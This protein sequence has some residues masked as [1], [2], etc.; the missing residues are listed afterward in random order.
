MRGELSKRRA[1]R[2]VRGSTALVIAVGLALLT[3]PAAVSA[4]D[5][6]GRTP[7]VLFPAFH[8]TKLQVTVKN[9]TV[10]PDCP[11]SGSFED[12]FLN[13]H[14]ST[15]FSQ[16]CRD[17]LMTLRYDAT[18]KEPM[19]ERFS[20]QR[21]VTIQII[22]YGTTQ[23]APFYE[24]MYQALEV[25]GYQRNQDIRVAGYDAR[26][27]PDMG[28]F[29]QRTKKLIEETYHDNGNRPVHLVGHS[30]GPLYAQYLLTHTTR[31]W[32]AKYIHGFTPIAGNFPGQGALY[33]ILFTGLNIQDFSFPATKENA[34]SSSRMYLTAPSSYMSS[35]DPKIFGD[36]ETVVLD[37]STGKS[38]TPKD[39]PQ[40]FTDAG[41]PW[42]R[43][44]AKYYVGFV[45]FADS[46][47]F[48]N[49]DVYG[50]KGSGIDTLVGLSLNGLS[51]GQL[52]DASTQFFTRKGDINQEDITNEAILAWQAMPC[53]HFSLTDNPGIDHFSLPSNAGVLSRLVATLP[54][55]RSRCRR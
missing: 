51:V 21:G 32:K 41:L 16:V 52:T 20:N 15:T 31:A 55:A 30:N 37:T 36:R 13:D 49:V 42:A 34:E 50:E 24:S 35:A 9:Q 28:G 23:S 10:A 53:F 4:S 14:P 5:H 40:L 44:I 54:L 22:G 2:S 6:S 19:P 47:S 48:P 26:L 33:P 45:K 7:V 12:W 38:Y 29:L 18:S 11:R 39:Y 43:D 8:F 25:A 46:A 17:K 1:L 27:T 3:G